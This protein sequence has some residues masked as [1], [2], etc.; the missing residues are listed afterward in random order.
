MLYSLELLP[1]LYT[2][3]VILDRFTVRIH[4]RIVEKGNAWARLWYWL[5]ALDIEGS[6]HISIPLDE[7]C[8]VFNIAT[9]TV[10]QWLRDG[11]AAGAFR[12]WK[13]RAGIL[14]SHLGSLFAVCQ[15]LGLREAKKGGR[16]EIHGDRVPRIGI[17]A[18]GAVADVPLFE[19]LS[20]EKLRAAATAAIAQRLQQLSRYAAWANLPKQARKTHKLPQPDAFFQSGE[21]QGLSHNNALGSIP[22]CLH[23]GKHRIWVSKG[24]IP[25]GASQNAIARER[26]M[27]DRTVRRHLKAVGV[28][29]RQVVQTK[30]A[31]RLVVRGLEWDVPTAPEPDISLRWNRDRSSLV[32]EGSYSLT[33]PSG[34]VGNPRTFEVTRER[35][36]EYGDHVYI[37]RTNLYNPTLKL[38][39][40]AASRRQFAK[41]SVLQKAQNFG[42]GPCSIGGLNES[43]PELKNLE[44]RQK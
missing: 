40:M 14:R 41:Y 36:F 21:E 30:A 22:C 42:R 26:G 43:M 7:I 6:G 19:I 28:E 15:R 37:Y 17:P 3:E 10:R 8:T 23:I 4:P 1:S 34:R 9:S 27:S 38:C 33:E 2:A 16:H 13:I 24:F 32:Y 44:S 5:R 18:W 12:R 20:L 25:F 35:F 39:T 11:V 29:S 31:Y